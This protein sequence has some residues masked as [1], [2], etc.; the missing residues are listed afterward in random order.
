MLP[1]TKMVCYSNKGVIMEG[2]KKPC[3]S[4]KGVIMERK[5]KPC[6]SNKGVIIEEEKMAFFLEW[7]E[8]RGRVTR[9][10]G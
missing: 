5:K 10:M 1:R 4:N 3:Y 2:K 9:I 7:R 6:Y 8:R